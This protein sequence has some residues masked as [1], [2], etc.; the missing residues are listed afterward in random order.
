MVDW[1][2]VERLRKSGWDW[3]EVAEDPK[4]GFHAAPGSGDPGRALLV[5]YQR[6]RG[7]TDHAEVTPINPSKRLSDV[8]ERTWGL[9]RIGYLLAPLI[10]VWALIAF[11]APS[12]VGLVLPAVPYVALILV[13]VVCLLLYGLLRTGQRWNRIYRNTLVTGVVVGLVFT[14]VVA[15]TGTVLFGCPYLPPSTSL[16]SQPAPGWAKA[17]V[18]SWEQEG[19]PV[20]YF[21]GATWCPY[22]S[23]SS[24]AM[25]KALTEF[26]VGY[27]GAIG[28][29]PGTSFEYSSNDAAG[30]YTPEVVLSNAQVS[31]PAVDFPASEYLWTPTSG[32]EGT[33]PATSNCVQQA[34]V[35]AYS[36]GSIPFVALNGQYIHGGTSLILPDQIST[37][38]NGANGGYTTVA[39]D[40]L[41]ETGAPW[42]AMH[43]QAGWICAF[44]L[45]CQGYATV[46]SFLNADPALSDPGKYQWTPAMVGLVDSDLAQL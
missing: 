27:D 7:R 28:G 8:S 15:L 26:Q 1:D 23:A 45:H 30:P 33:F 11:L 40:V 37:W 17:N 43:V 20:F 29:L 19:K 2:R 12:P 34:Y 39:T 3:E 31:S 32:T 4:V 46:A 25:W 18:A 13:A 41:Q 42:S 35:S 5:L 9:A 38:A 21:Y 24:W 16:S 22:C 14:G 10:G 6:R 36:G 44:L